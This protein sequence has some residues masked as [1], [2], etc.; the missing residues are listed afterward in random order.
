MVLLPPRFHVSTRLLHK[1]VV[2][3]VSTAGRHVTDSPCQIHYIAFC[4]IWPTQAAEKGSVTEPTRVSARRRPDLF[5]LETKMPC[6][7]CNEVNGNLLLL[8]AQ[9]FA[10]LLSGL[11]A[12]A[13]ALNLNLTLKTSY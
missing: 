12:T 4:C 10:D 5:I 8:I 6:S 11:L 9:L 3:A 2:A 7:H 13:R 1:V